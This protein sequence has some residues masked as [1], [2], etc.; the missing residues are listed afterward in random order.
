MKLQFIYY[1][2]CLFYFAWKK[3]SLSN[4]VATHEAP[5]TQK[6][7]LNYFL[8]QVNLYSSVWHLNELF[9]NKKSVIL[10]MNNRQ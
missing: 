1:Y 2:F 7:R 5:L 4:S 10:V 8:K 3:T 9:V 6:P